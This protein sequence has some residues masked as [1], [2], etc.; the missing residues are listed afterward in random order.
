LKPLRLYVLNFMCIDNAYIDF[1]QFSAAQ[2][3]G[4]KENNDNFSNGV[5]KTSLFK[6]IEYVLFNEADVN[7]KMIILEDAHMCQVVFD[8]EINGVEYRLSRKRTQKGTTDLTLLQRNTQDGNEEEVYHKIVNGKYLPHLDKKDIEKYW[9]DLSGSRAGDTE[10]DLTKLIKYNHKS[11]R[12]TIHFVQDDKGGLATLSPEKRKG[13][14][15]EALNLTVYAKLEKIAKEKLAQ[16]NKDIEKHQILIDGLGDPDKDLILLSHQ[17]LEF[18]NIL[19]TKNEQLTSLNQDNDTLQT[20]INQLTQNHSQLE[21]KFASFL[22]QEQSLT[23]DCAKLEKMIR[24]YAEKNT[25]L[26]KLTKEIIEKINASKE[27]KTKLNALNYSQ[28]ENLTKQLEENKEKVITHNLNIKS[29]MEKYEDLKIPLPSGSVCKA[30]RKSMSDEERKNCQE[31]INQD[32]KNIQ[33]NIQSSKNELSK[34]NPEIIN[35]QKNI[36]ELQSSKQTLTRLTDQI[37]NLEKEIKEKKITH[38]EHLISIANFNRDLE[39]KKSKLEEIKRELANS[40]V[41]EADL[42]KTQIQDKRSELTTSTSKINSLTKEITQ[43]TNNQAVNTHNIEQKTNDKAKKIE[44]KKELLSL[45]NQASKYPA[46]IQGFSSSGIPNLI[47]QD[48]LDDLQMEANQLLD[49]LKPGLQLSFLIEKDNEEHSDTLD[50]KYNI[51]GRERY[52]EQLSGAM[53]LAVSFSLKLGLSFVLQKR[54]GVD[55][56]LLLLDEID[57]SLDKAGVDAFA[58]IIKT[59]QQDF[60]ILVITHNDRLKDKFKSTILV[61]QDI[62][63]ISTA[64]VIST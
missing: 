35:C 48:V 38:S 16:L 22:Q 9:K 45:Q 18:D 62:N 14:L 13:I 8:F 19:Q 50:I 43:I 57:Q 54:L 33:Q 40:S 29:W 53:R 49:L 34:L 5:G 64:K 51:N 25:N 52:Y 39:E 47:I 63:M 41:K 31:H 4:Q 55:I 21:N 6:A 59:F 12:A 17:S 2:I 56:K 60:S 58:D 30:C 44:L 10:R 42:L 28:I 7:L 1:T 15:K 11:F 37:G 27:T 46:V 20:N 32:I 23:N 3:V 61:E 36:N 26:V 24:D